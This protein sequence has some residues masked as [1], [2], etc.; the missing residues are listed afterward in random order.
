MLSDRQ[1]WVAQGWIQEIQD[2]GDRNR[3]KQE[4]PL[5]Q[6][7]T[8]HVYKLGVEGPTWTDRKIYQ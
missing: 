7:T 5:Q 2:Q 1:S 3:S 6:Q 4:N 8:V